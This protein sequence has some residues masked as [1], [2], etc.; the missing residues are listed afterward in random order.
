[1]KMKTDRFITHKRLASMFAIATLAS[2]A[3]AATLH[4]P[5]DYPTIQAAVDAAAP[6]GDEIL[7]APGVYQQQVFIAEKKLTLSG[8]AGTVIEAWT[9][10]NWI[11]GG[12]S[13]DLVY[14]T[15]SADVVI[16]NIEFNGRRLAAS[17]PNQNA[18]LEAVLFYGASGRVENCVFTG[19]RGINNLGNPTTPPRGGMG[20]GLAAFSP[21]STGSGVIHVQVLNCTFTD[22][23][24][25][26]AFAGD[27]GPA[28]IN[29]PTLLRATFTVAGNTIAGVGPTSLGYQD[30]IEIYQGASGVIKNNRII[31]HCNTSGGNWFNWSGGIQAF[32]VAGRTEPLKP[33]RI[34]CNTFAGNQKHLILVLADDSQVINNVFDGSGSTPASDGIW[35][36]GSTVRTAINVFTN[37]NRGV[38]LAANSS[39]LLT[40]SGVAVNP[41]LLGN[42]FYD[43]TTPVTVQAGVVNASELGSEFSPGGFGDLTCSPARGLPG[44]TVT[45]T[46]TA[47]ASASTVL[48][49]GQS[50][51]FTAGADPDSEIVATVPVHATTGPIMVI[52]TMQG[53]LRSMDPFTVPVLLAM[54]QP[55][56]DTIELSWSADASDLLLECTSSLATPDWQQMATSPSVGNDVVTWTGPLADGARF[57]R[58]RQP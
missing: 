4:V 7:I 48:F 25:S 41:A 21:V 58:L 55:G 2:A 36:T 53:N 51:E 16:R 45:L 49:N 8:S 26:M 42:Q 10:M 30:G 35:L 18:L 3:E 32:P 52:T 17:M 46:G 38:I 56:D 5:A 11:A 22:N 33:L 27:F 54:A 9:G 47:L 28:G 43:V 39:Q 44:T 6:A 57:F 40:G 50:A 23:G 20:F 29:D 1:M 13:H 19:F 37:L 24:I 31:D 15:T 12:P 14:I 34:E